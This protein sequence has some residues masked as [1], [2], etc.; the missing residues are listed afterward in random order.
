MSDIEI[1]VQPSAQK[2]SAKLP[3]GRKLLEAAKRVRGQHGHLGLSDAQ[4]L[5]L[6]EEDAAQRKEAHRQRMRE[7]GR[8]RAA[9][10]TRAVRKPKAPAEVP[11]P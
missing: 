11:Q 8:Q 5:L 10:K 6:I 1:Q 7:Y 3:S 9:A 4:L 2:T